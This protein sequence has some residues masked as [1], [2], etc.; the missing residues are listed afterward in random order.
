GSTAAGNDQFRFDAGLRVLAPGIEVR[1]PV[2]D[3]GISR[4]EET[5]YCASRGVAVPAKTTRYTINDGLWGPT[6]GA[7]AARDTSEPR[8][9]TLARSAAHAEREKLVMTKEQRQLQALVAETHGRL[10]HE[11]LAFDP[12]LLDADAHLRATQSRVRGEAKLRFSPGRFE[13]VGVR[14]PH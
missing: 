12:A 13:V 14:S 5:A 6:I 10:L 4:E 2:R 3:S 8:P 9:A 7:G 11:G 1:A